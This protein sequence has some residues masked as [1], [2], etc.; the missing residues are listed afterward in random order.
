MT[1][2]LP[3]QDGAPRESLSF[4]H[5]SGE[6]LAPV[7]APVVWQRTAQLLELLNF[8]PS[9]PGNTHCPL[10][11]LCFS[12]LLDIP[13]LTHMALRRRPKP[14]DPMQVSSCQ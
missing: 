6:R 2:P 9:R 7:P 3:L 8:S 1:Q 13:S 5:E 4:A 11:Y 14:R 10:H 12:L